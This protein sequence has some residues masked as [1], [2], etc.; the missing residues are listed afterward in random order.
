MG[1]TASAALP[2]GDPH[3]SGMSPDVGPFAAPGRMHPD[4]PVV[5]AKMHKKAH[6]QNQTRRD[7][8]HAA[9]KKQP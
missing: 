4:Y 6:K 2:P 1:D 8:M 7:E 3:T 9:G 5:V